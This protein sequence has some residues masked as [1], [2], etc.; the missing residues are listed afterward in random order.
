M[1]SLLSTQ[2]PETAIS[3]IGLLTQAH[4]IT[5][6][7]QHMR[8]SFNLNSAKMCSNFGRVKEKLSQYFAHYSDSKGVNFFDFF[9]EHIRL[10]KGVGCR[11]HLKEDL[12]EEL[13]L[14]KEMF[15]TIMSAKNENK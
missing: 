1:D 6:L 5:D 13:L 11:S 9:L 7:F 14:F 12:F 3:M 4:K 2:K 8:V 10:P 15:E